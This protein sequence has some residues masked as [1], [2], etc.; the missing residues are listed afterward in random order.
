MGTGY[1]GGFGRTSGNTLY[2]AGDGSFMGNKETF[3][4]YIRRRKD[5]DPDGKFDLIA[6][7]T[8]KSVEVEHKGT[9]V[10]IDSRTAAKLIRQMPG[11]KKGQPIRL[12]SCNTGAQTASF[13]QN[14][15]NK[16]NVTVWAPTDYLWVESTGKY[17]VAGQTNSGFP[18][19]SKRGHF[20]AFTPGGN[21]K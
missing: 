3:L 16:L 20:K 8:A 21:K 7:G 17:Y 11:Y 13:A 10:Q 1:H 15:A 6:H 12:L 5:V 18:D 4:Q 2:A 14:L 19:M 9:V